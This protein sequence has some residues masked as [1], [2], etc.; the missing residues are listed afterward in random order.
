MVGVRGRGRGLGNGFLERGDCRIGYVCDVDTAYFNR[1]DEFA[2]RQQGRKPKCVQDLRKALDDKSVDAIVVAT[3]DHWHALATVWGV[4]AGKDVY[5]EKPP[6]HSCWEGQQMI[7]AARKHDQIVQVG[8]QN[9]SA[10][11]NMA[12][13][14]YIEEGKLGT[15]HMCRVYNQ[16]GQH[17]F[18]AVPDSS[19]PASLDWDMWN[20]PAPEAAYNLNRHR[21]W[22][23]WWCYSGGDMANDGVHQ[24]DLARWLC[25]VELPKMVFAAGGRYAE[26]GIDQTPDSMVATFAYDKLVMTFELTL[27][28]PYMLKS[29]GV[30]RNSDIFPYWPQNATRIEIYGTEGLMLVGRHGGGWQAYVRPKNRKPVVRDQMYGRFPD[31]EHKENFIHCIRT[32]KRPNADIAKVHTSALLIHY[33]NL[34]IRTGGTTLKIDPR[35]EHIINH[36]QAQTLFRREYRKPWVVPEEV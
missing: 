7:K 33:A 27:Y 36:E 34:S 35:S 25:G 8:T 13:K 17:N 29:D 4:Q 18:R 3:P 16:K 11:Y 14:R 24:L 6:T 9:R 15:I 19:P 2:R 31:P 20:G 30:L 28:T 5:V 12:A 1:A 26:P 10:P 21:H 22:H 23:G 32:R